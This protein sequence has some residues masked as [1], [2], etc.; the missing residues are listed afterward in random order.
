MSRVLQDR[1]GFTVS[2]PTFALVR[3]R[4]PLRYPRLLTE[5]T[6]SLMLAFR[7]KAR[8]NESRSSGSDAVG[9]SG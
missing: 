9:G 4:Y 1:R 6:P 2:K 5:T 7:G 3:P 8:K